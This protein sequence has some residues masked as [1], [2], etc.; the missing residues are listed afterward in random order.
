M[1]ASQVLT[2]H[3]IQRA[4]DVVQASALAGLELA[5]AATLLEKE[6]GGGHNIYGHD[7]VQTG[8]FYEKGGPVTK[9]NFTAYKAHRKKLGAQGVGPTQLTLP[10]FQDL[11][12]AAGGCYDWKTNAATGFKI[13]AGHISHAG[14]HDGFRRYNGSG[15]AAEHYADDAVAKLQ[16]WR[17]RLGASPTREPHVTRPVL[18]Q[19]DT[20]AV[21]ASLQKFLNKTFPLYSHIDLA[22]QRYG[23]MTAKVIAE[24]QRRAGVSGDGVDPKGRSIGAPTWASLE[25]FGFH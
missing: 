3:G 14:V 25:F 2:Q 6:S 22:P 8:G 7:G 15:K 1:G 9:A 5:A 18:K 24:F 16:V 13:L 17:K 4:A 23:P 19:G 20:G 12:D 10:A 21:V 11:A